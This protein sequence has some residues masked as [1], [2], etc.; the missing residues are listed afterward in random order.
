MSPAAEEG[1]APAATS[2]SRRRRFSWGAVFCFGSGRER[3][4]EALAEGTTPR[5]RWA[6]R[7]KRRTV[8]V[9]GDLVPGTAGP[10]VMRRGA[11]DGKEPRKGLRLQGCCFL[12]PPRTPGRKHSTM[13][14]GSSRSTH[15]KQQ[16]QPENTEQKQPPPRHRPKRLPHGGQPKPLTAAARA[17]RNNPAALP[18]RR[19]REHPPSRHA[20]RHRHQPAWARSA[21]W[22]GCP[23]WP[24]CPWRGCSAGA[25]GPCPAC[26]RGSPRCPGSGSGRPA[27]VRPAG[28]GGSEEAVAHV[29]TW[30]PGKGLQEAHLKNLLMADLESQHDMHTPYH[31]RGPGWVQMES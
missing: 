6:R 20:R 8:P 18:P 24:R 10:D 31:T 21:P 5:E 16:R 9:D 30:T 29:V 4:E 2:A 3:A 11:D 22:W 27:P 1:V 13:D 28:I 12:A 17:A 23:W 19:E 14:G 15:D 26:A 7:R 25:S